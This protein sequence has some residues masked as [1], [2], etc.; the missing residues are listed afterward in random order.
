MTYYGISF[1]LS[2]V[3]GSLTASFI[4]SAAAELP[5]YLAAAWAID[6]C[7]RHNTMAACTLLGG[8]G[9]ALCAAAPPGGARIA[10]ASVGKFGISAAFA[11][12][13]IYTSELFPT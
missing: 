12:A 3:G 7:G 11:V 2:G 1:A 5:S 10:L 8:V 6:R 9:C 4:A 13:S